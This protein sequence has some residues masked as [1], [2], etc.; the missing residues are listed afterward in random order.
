MYL[1]RIVEVG[2]P[3][4]VFASPQH[5]YT[6]ALMSVL[7]ESPLEPVVLTGEPPDATRIPAGCRFHP[8]CPALASGEAAAVAEACHGKSL[9]IL[10]GDPDGHR[11][12]C[13]LVD[14]R[15]GST[16]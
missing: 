1:G 2:T 11:C 3:E 16:A 9:P 12:A 15:E 4:E 7:P 14:V 6:R 8:R 5:P 13:H 10:S